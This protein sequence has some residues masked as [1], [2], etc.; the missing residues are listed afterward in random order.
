MADATRTLS[1]KWVGD[2]KSLEQSAGQAEKKVG[3]FGKALGGIGGIAAGAFGGA[4]LAGGISAAADFLGDA[5][6]AAMEDEAAQKTLAKALK[7]TAGATDEQVASTEAWITKQGKALGVAD[8]KLRPALQTLSNAT[9]DVGKSQE[10]LSLA[11]DVSAGSG[12]DLEAVALGLAKAQGGSAKELKSL[13]FEVDEARFKS[14]GLA[15]V[16]ETLN[17]AMGGQAAEAANTSAGK[18]ARMQLQFGEMKE[19]LGAKLLPALTAVLDFLMNKLVPGIGVVVEAVKVAVEWMT[20]HW[21]GVQDAIQPVIDFV[22]KLF[23]NLVQMVGGVILVFQ[24]LIDFIVGVFTGDWDR[25]WKGIQ[26]IFQGFFNIISGYI[27]T[28]IDY[29]MLVFAY[30]WKAIQA[31]WDLALAAIEALVKWYIN[32]YISIIMF[33]VNTLKT[34][35]TGAW[36]GLTSGL[37][38]AWDWVVSFLKDLPNKAVAVLMYAVSFGQKIGDAIKKAITDALD[39]LTDGLKSVVSGALNTVLRGYNAIDF[40]I[41]LKTPSIPGLPSFHFDIDDIFPD[42]PLIHLATGGV[43]KSDGLAYLHAN[44]VVAPLAAAGIGTTVIYNVNVNVA[45]TANLAD[46]GRQTVDAIRAYERNNG[47]TWRAS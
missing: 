33:F 14:E 3:G 27:Q 9:G 28:F 46:A 8:D 31:A 13:G 40:G 47:A 16:Q 1:V 36:D 21:A 15:Y 22:V 29:I 39:G 37:T 20:D 7:Q 4:A 24:G 19:E 43:T 23:G 42:V 12:Q 18:M 5:T 25:A 34:I 44:E 38:A 45:P 41:H 10:L 30:P 6:K 32:L 2:T 17:K 26:K 35:F 11:M